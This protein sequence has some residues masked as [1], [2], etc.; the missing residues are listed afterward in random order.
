MI[1]TL[2]KKR[3]VLQKQAIAVRLEPVQ[4]HDRPVYEPETTF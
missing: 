4:M 2:T 1:I 3:V